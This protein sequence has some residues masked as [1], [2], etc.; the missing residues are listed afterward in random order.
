MQTI[1]T[2]EG[3]VHIVRTLSDA[4]GLWDWLDPYTQ[5]GI[6][7]GLDTEATGLKHF[8]PSYRL[9]TCQMS[10]GV[11]TF[12]I[13]HERPELAQANVVRTLVARHP[14][15]IAHYAEYDIRSLAVK[16]PGSIRLDSIEAHVRDSQTVLAYADPRTVTGGAKL[17]PRIRLDRALKPTITREIGSNTLA[18]VEQA[19][20]ARFR[21]LV[22]K[23]I[24]SVKAVKGWGFEHIDLDDEIYNAY[25]GLD[26]M[27]EIRLYRKLMTRI[28]ARGQRPVVEADMRRQWHVDLMTL[29]GMPVDIEYVRWLDDQ[30]EQVVRDNMVRLCQHKVAISGMGPSVGAAFE[31]LGVRSTRET[32]SG[33][34]SWDGAMLDVITDNAALA[35]TVAHIEAIEL[36]KAISLVRKS[37]KFRSAYLMP[38]LDSAGRDGRVHCSM[39]MCGAVTGRNSASDPPVQQMPKRKDKRVRPAFVAP[40]GWVIVTADF[41]Q[42]EP[43]TM[44]ALSGDLNLQFDIEQGDLNDTLASLTYGAMFIAEQGDDAATL[45][46]QLRQRAKF[47]FLAWCYG[48]GLVKLASLLVVSVEVA[49][50]IMGNWIGRYPDLQAFRERMNALSAVTLE[51]G[52]VVPL[53][54]RWEYTP[55]GLRD[56][57][58]P[59]RLGLNA[60]TQGEQADLL[61][62]GFDQFVSR[63]WSWALLMLV[64]DEI[65]ACVPEALGEQCRAVLEECMTM[66]FH[67]FPIRCKAKVEGTSWMRRPDEYDPAVLGDLI[68]EAEEYAA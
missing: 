28:E 25:A 29:R 40:P 43:R 37:G 61:R 26:A 11:D 34:D 38:M 9:R 49:R 13:H 24:N 48:C 19:L 68:L 20:V 3:P 62:R 60:V 41:S 21:Q 31:R 63:G 33:G 18:E 54:D 46:Y 16:V 15:W 45:S 42:G 6:D 36:A 57:G 23:G 7:L 56:T 53:W 44:A 22:P 64:H 65:V 52:R 67:G 50:G 51:S 39:R 4:A 58:K 14:R 55:A 47:A 17:D 8:D 30:L 32:K 2:P 5:Q 66:D 35:T 59:S 10:D 12:V 1:A 27:M